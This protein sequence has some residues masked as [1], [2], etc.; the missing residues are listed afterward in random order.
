MYSAKRK[1]VTGDDTRIFQDYPAS[2]VSVYSTAT[3]KERTRLDDTI[4]EFP[5]L[6]LAFS[7]LTVGLS[8]VVM[9]V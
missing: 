4:V 1:I 8:S 2:P 9:F 6:T 7:T 5:V 3:K